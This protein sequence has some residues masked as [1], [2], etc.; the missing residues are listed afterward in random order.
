MKKLWRYSQT[1]IKMYNSAE[2]MTSTDAQ[3]D[4]QEIAAH[5]EKYFSTTAQHSTAQQAG[6]QWQPTRERQEPEEDQD[7]DSRCTEL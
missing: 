5:F 4:W 7:K 3:L 1:A 2:E 6:R